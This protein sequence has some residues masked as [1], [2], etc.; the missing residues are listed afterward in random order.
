MDPGSLAQHIGRCDVP[1][2]LE[3][4]EVQHVYAAGDPARGFR[5]GDDPFG[6]D[7]HRFTEAADF[8]RDVDLRPR[9]GVHGQVQCA[10]REPARFGGQDASACCDTGKVESAGGIGR[11]PLV[12]QPCGRCKHDGGEGD[13]RAAGVSHAAGDAA[14]L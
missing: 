4:N 9:A 2:V 10:R 14:G 12:L 8:E 1:A 13:R 6:D 7:L 11:G 5:A 3:G